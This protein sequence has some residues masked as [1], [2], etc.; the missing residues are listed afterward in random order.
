MGINMMKYIVSLML[1]VCLSSCSFKNSAGDCIGVMD[2]P[3]PGVK[4]SVSWWNGF[5]AF[6][7]SHTIIIPV[8][9]VAKDI[10]C[11]VE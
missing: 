8:Y 7:F 11:P 6:F 4:Y 10:Q 1:I 2:T 3:V 9:T 5:V